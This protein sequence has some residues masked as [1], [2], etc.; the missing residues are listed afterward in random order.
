MNKNQLLY[1]KSL[2][3]MIDADNDKIQIITRSL[4]GLRNR[5]SNEE[6]KVITE[7]ICR[8]SLS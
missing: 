7:V 3:E 2:Y 8:S 6:I 5:M 4:F 1:I